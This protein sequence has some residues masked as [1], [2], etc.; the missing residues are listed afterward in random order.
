MNEKQLRCLDAC[1]VLR[2]MKD[3]FIAMD[4]ENE[5]API[6]KYYFKS[7]ADNQG[8]TL[9]GTGIVKTTGVTTGNYTQ[10]KVVT[11]S[12]DQS[13]VGQKF[14]VISTAKTDGTIYACYTDAGTTS[15]GF[16]VEISDIPFVEDEDE[17]D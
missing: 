4:A 16:Y 2:E 6:I 8:E 3:W 14:Y 5:P 1:P 12:S 15:A 17:D 11:N 9:W 7:Y 13:F 10:V